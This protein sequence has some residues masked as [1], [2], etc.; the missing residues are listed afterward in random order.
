MSFARFYLPPAAWTGS[1][2]VLSGEEARHCGQVTRHGVGDKVRVFD[3]QGRQAEA[4]IHSLTKEAVRLEVLS[5]AMLPAPAC[6][7]TLVQAVVKGDTMEWII[8]KAVELGVQRIIPWVA[9]RSI[10]R[11]NAAEAG[12]KRDKWQRVALEACKQCGQAWLP[13]V[14][15]PCE[16]PQVLQLTEATSFKL[17]ASLQANAASL[18][19]GWPNGVAEAALAIGPEGD[20]TPEEHRTLQTAGWQPWSLGALTLRSE[21]AAICALSILSYELYSH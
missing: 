2:L 6:A 16:L 14:A 12:R 10:V 20:F 18:R 8:E 3:G 19:G 4:A 5:E 7:L 13:E 21:T 17:M 1:E 9:Q 11:L 15:A